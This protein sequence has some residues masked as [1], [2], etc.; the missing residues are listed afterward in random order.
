MNN[1][2]IE[3]RSEILLSVHRALLGAITSKLRA[4]CV[5]WSKIDGKLSIK[6]YFVFYKEITDDNKDDCECVAT[7]VVADFAHGYIETEFLQISSSQTLPKLGRECVF[8]R[9]EL[10]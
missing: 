5:D 3:N 10:G 2:E 6:L 7:E 4:V 9:K 8:K 1:A